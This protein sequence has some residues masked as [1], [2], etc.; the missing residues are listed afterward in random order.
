LISVSGDK[1]DRDYRQLVNLASELQMFRGYLSPEEEKREGKL[2]A[3]FNSA[4]N[5]F[6]YALLREQPVADEAS[7]I[8]SQEIDEMSSA[9]PDWA[10]T[11]DYVRGE[12]LTRIETESS[13]SPLVRHVLRWTP[14]ALGVVGLI[15]YFTVRFISA[16]EIDQPIE[17]RAGIEQRAGAFQKAIRYDDWMSG[18]TR[19][20]WMMELLLWPIEPTDAE[21]L[22]A[23]EFASLTADG[24]Q[25]LTNERM[26]CGGPA[27]SGTDQV[28]GEQIELIGEV[29]DFVRKEDTKWLQPPVMT[30][31]E[32]IKTAYP[33]R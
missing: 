14:L 22:G 10:S 7:R 25:A 24:F 33:C 23:K 28:S 18:V 15:A 11:L 17:S 1:V 31:L 3:E 26:I 12:L 6:V 29:A 32:P 30:V 16:V 21:I 20:R 8:V 27:E 4:R 9:Q 2:R 5:K 19:R 13:K